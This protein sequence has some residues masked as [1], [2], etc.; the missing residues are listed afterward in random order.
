MLLKL[1]NLF[2][3]E[4]Y[5]AYI[6][7]ILQG[8]YE[9]V[10]GQ[11]QK[12]LDD[13]PRYYI[14][15]GQVYLLKI[16]DTQ[17]NKLDLREQCYNATMC[18]KQAIAHANQFS[19][20][21]EILG[22]A[23]C[24]LGYCSYLENN[25]KQ[26]LL[27]F[28]LAIA[29]QPEGLEAHL[30]KTLAKSKIAEI[31]CLHNLDKGV[32]EHRKA[33]KELLNIL[34][35]FNLSQYS[36]YVKDFIL[37]TMANI[38]MAAG[39]NKLAYR[40]FTAVSS[41]IPHKNSTRSLNVDREAQLQFVFAC[42]QRLAEEHEKSYLFP[43]TGQAFTRDGQ[44]SQLTI[45]IQKISAKYDI[46]DPVTPQAEAVL[47]KLNIRSLRPKKD[48]ISTNNKP[49]VPESKKVSSVQHLRS[50]SDSNE[51]SSSSSN[52]SS[53]KD[54]KYAKEPAYKNVLEQQF[55]EELQKCKAQFI[56][57]SKEC[58][59]A[60]N[61]LLRDLTSK[62]QSLDT[63][64]KNAVLKIQTEISDGKL[65]HE[66]A[67]S[68]S[69]EQINLSELSRI[70]QKTNKLEADIKALKEI[71]QSGSHPA[72]VDNKH[73]AQNSELTT[74]L[75]IRIQELEKVYSQELA[76]RKDLEKVQSE[77]KIINS[78]P[79]LQVFYGA[80]RYRLYAYQ[81]GKL[82]LS[83]GE[84]QPAASGIL[85]T[86]GNV[87]AF[88]TVGIASTIAD[89]EQARRDKKQTKSAHITSERYFHNGPEVEKVFE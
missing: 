63:E 84:F 2:W 74:D 7:Q 48:K 33:I 69:D 13:D 49:V 58:L 44:S 66:N 6:K 32:Q 42:Y 25:F 56:K 71:L 29:T 30:G 60:Q 86:A 53:P 27:E 46:S 79:K 50:I 45:Q 26:A 22:L 28:E 9:L 72:M 37:T 12:H 64:A 34:E 8:N 39:Y 10:L 70:S 85:S 54:E 80:L 17:G 23:Y 83:T 75:Q 21:N 59:D 19:D 81:Y 88:F 16:Q 67:I 3:G 78:N 57:E 41:V 5:Q 55:T 31:L 65:N 36:R 38:F 11:M 18:F 40:Y 43:A 35:K 52:A 61:K 87:T 47:K 82:A 20:E 24:G 68:L 1:I 51:D 14:L 4:P 76:F 89:W 77:M 62:A 15:L 73:A